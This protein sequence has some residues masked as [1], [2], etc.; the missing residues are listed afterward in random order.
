MR[1]R[2]RQSKPIRA[3]IGAMMVA[4]MMYQF[5]T[6]SLRAIER[7]IFGNQFKYLKNE[8]GEHKKKR[9]IYPCAVS[10]L[11]RGVLPKER[12]FQKMV[13]C[14]PTLATLRG[15]PLWKVLEGYGSYLPDELARKMSREVHNIFFDPENE[16]PKEV[17]QFCF[18]DDRFYELAIVPLERIGNIEAFTILAAIA[19]CESVFY[20]DF[21]EGSTFSFAKKVLLRLI[22]FP[23]IFE[24][25]QPLCRY[26]HKFFAGPVK[27]PIYI[28]DVPLTLSEFE[29]AASELRRF[30]EA[31]GR[32][33]LVKSTFSDQLELAYWFR[34]D[35]YNM[36][37]IRE[38]EDVYETA[39]RFREPVLVDPPHPLYRL[40]RRIRHRSVR[41]GLP[42]K[43]P[44]ARYPSVPFRIA[45]ALEEMAA[46]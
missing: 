20:A 31:M 43:F 45:N 10:K 27:N 29:E 11:N 25:R 34:E 38:I 30:L 14:C 3:L 37:T 17:N 36:D 6:K 4:E 22:A 18:A 46:V 13:A 16:K 39:Y 19:S 44:I 33:G 21:G 26:L 8:A 5:S 35:S 41:S 40:L 15:L 1:K 12:R 28:P 23:P 32:L 9:L 7:I 42:I 2:I 24:I